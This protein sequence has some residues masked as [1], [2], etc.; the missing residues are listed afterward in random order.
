ML[1][2]APTNLEWQVHLG[3]DDYRWKENITQSSL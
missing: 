2:I 1:I 3:V